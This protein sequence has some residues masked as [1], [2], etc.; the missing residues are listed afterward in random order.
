MLQDHAGD[1]GVVVEVLSDDD[2]VVRRMQLGDSYRV[3]RSPGLAMA[4]EESVP[5]LTVA[6]AR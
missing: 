5:G 6:Q 2:Q 1:A 3:R 4:L